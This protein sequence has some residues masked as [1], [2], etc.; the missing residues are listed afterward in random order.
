MSSETC[1]TCAGSLNLESCTRLLAFAGVGVGVRS[2]G[3]R[4]AS[5][6][7]RHSLAGRLRCAFIG[8]SVTRRPG[9]DVRPD[10]T[11]VVEMASFGLKLFALASQ[12]GPFTLGRGAQSLGFASAHGRT[13]SA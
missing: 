13:A 10:Q 1:R 7:G 11:S 8:P 6:I 2:R 9:S 3:R 4:T 5:A 12:V